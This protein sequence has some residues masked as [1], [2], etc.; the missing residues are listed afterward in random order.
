MARLL[1]LEDHSETL[2]AQNDRLELDLARTAV[3]T[4]DL[5]RGHLDPVEATV[6]IGA[7]LSE[8]VIHGAREVLVFARA[9]GLAVVHVTVTLRETE[10]KTFYRHPKFSEAALIFSKQNPLSEAQRRGVLHNVEGSI[11]AELAPEIGPEPG[12]YWIR[13]KKTYSSF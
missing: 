5:H 11:Q 1:E 12:D 8:R 13:T 10:A 4:V 7:A 2:Q 9:N 6:P 3:L